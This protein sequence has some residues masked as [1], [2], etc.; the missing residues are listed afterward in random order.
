M[1]IPAKLQ[2]INQEAAAS[3]S[4]ALSKLT[5]SPVKVEIRRTEI[6]Q[7]EKIRPKWELEDMVVGVYLP[8]TGDVKGG[9][10]LT[11]SQEVA[12][13]LSDLLARRPRGTTRKL[14]PLDESA[15]KEVGNILTGS[16]LTVLANRLQL[17]TVEGLPRLGSGMFGAF[18]DQFLIPS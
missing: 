1:K 14:T 6:G 5:A 13:A 15:I 8:V 16:Y 12:F 4:E 3:A 17:K 18:L 2:L 7:P 10:F 9:A 11:F